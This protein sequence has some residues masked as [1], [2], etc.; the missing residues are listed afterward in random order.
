MGFWS[1]AGGP[2]SRTKSTP[3]KAV[4]KRKGFIFRARGSSELGD[5]VQL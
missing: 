2:W 3:S 5:T 1:I 4:K